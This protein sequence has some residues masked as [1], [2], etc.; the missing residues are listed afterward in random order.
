[1]YAKMDF[2]QEASL[3]ASGAKPTVLCSL[4]IGSSKK[5]EIDLEVI[6]TYVERSLFLSLIMFLFKNEA[7]LYSF[8]IIVGEHLQNIFYTTSAKKLKEIRKYGGKMI[9]S[10]REYRLGRILGFPECCIRKFSR[11]TRA[12]LKNKGTKYFYKS[13]NLYAL[14]RYLKQCK[15]KDPYEL[16]YSLKFNESAYSS[17]SLSHIPCSPECIKTKKLSKKYKKALALLVFKKQTCLICGK[18]E[19]VPEAMKICNDCLLK[20]LDEYS[21]KMAEEGERIRGSKGVVSIKD[22]KKNCESFIKEVVK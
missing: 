21:Q 18:K 5:R 4:P 2:H 15:K 12:A 1:M 3:L 6:K 22:F 8:Q 19:N 13:T 11:D 14:T 16:S 20:K 7:E 17:P 9:E 10:S